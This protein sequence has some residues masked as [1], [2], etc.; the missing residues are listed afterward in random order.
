MFFKSFKKM[1]DVDSE[2]NR[3]YNHQY[4]A[5]LDEIESSF[6]NL[7]NSTA[8]V[9]KHA[10]DVTDQLNQNVELYEKRFDAIIN[11]VNNMIIIKTVNRQWTIV[12]DFACTLLG[13]NRETCIGKTNDEIMSIYPQLSTL[14]TAIDKAEKKSWITKSPAEIV[15]PLEV[16]NKS[17]SVTI[18]IKPIETEDEKA[19]EIVVI[20]KLV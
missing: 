11:T 12:N 6:D 16:N 18:I 17:A 9:I 7:K 19:H 1:F 14:L 8:E 5:K 10:A 4:Q 13:I 3:Y 20:G 2:I 15:I